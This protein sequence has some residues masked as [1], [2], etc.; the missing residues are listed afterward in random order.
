MAD[1][2]NPIPLFDVLALGD[3]LEFLD[4]TYRA[5]TRGMG[6][7]YG[8][9]FVIL[10]STVFLWYTR[11]TERRTDGQTDGRTGD[12]RYGIYAVARKKN[13]NR[14]GLLDISFDLSRFSISS[15]LFHIF[16]AVHCFRTHFELVSFT[17]ACNIGWVFFD[18]SIFD[19]T[20]RDIA[21]STSSIRPAA[22]TPIE[23]LLF[24]A[25]PLC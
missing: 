25:T 20:R 19:S 15:F 12:T 22:A 17:Q 24:T 18:Y 6:L 4:E 14:F 11:V 5:K 9:N 8:K 10:T 23:S 3:P 13:T 7:P 1:F 21:K 2:S 16:Y